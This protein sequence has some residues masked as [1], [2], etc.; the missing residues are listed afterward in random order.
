M[1]QKTNKVIWLLPFKMGKVATSGKQIDGQGRPD[2]VDQDLEP[3]SVLAG[4][5][6]F[7][8][9]TRCQVKLK[10]IKIKTEKGEGVCVCVRERKK[11]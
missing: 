11:R 4:F 7:R 5:P 2:Q 1:E 9:N 3:F 10:C 8:R 6:V